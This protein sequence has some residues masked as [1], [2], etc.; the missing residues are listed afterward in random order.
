MKITHA[1]LNIRHRD[2]DYHLQL[3]DFGRISYEQYD[4][5]MHC[6]AVYHLILIS[7]G[8]C[9]L[10]IGSRSPMLLERGT[11]IFLNP[12]TPHRFTCLPGIPVEHTAMLWRLVDR[13]GHSAIFPLQELYGEAPAPYLLQKLPRDF[14]LKVLAS[15]QEVLNHLRGRGTPARL[16]MM[17]Y[18]FWTELF[19]R[20]LFSGEKQPQSPYGE[21]VDRI[22]KLLTDAV[23]DAGFGNRQLARKLGLHPNYLNRRFREATGS[24]LQ[25]TLLQLRFRKARELLTDTRMQVG[26]IAEQCGFRDR[27]YFSRSFAARYGVSPLKFR[28]NTNSMPGFLKPDDPSD[29]GTP[30][31]AQEYGNNKVSWKDFS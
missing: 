24:S 27:C 3:D 22:L 12:L 2:R 23:G 1:F 15:H 29:I 9:Y 14:L 21:L 5:Q 8:S 4:P 20:L 7:R 31:E 10:E 6:H 16:P 25:E 19:E 13:H 18:R 28:K 11:L 26:E 30:Y 17:L